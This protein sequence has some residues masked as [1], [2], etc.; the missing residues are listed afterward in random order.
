MS[1]KNINFDDNE[2]RES[3]FYNS[4]KINNIE[5]IDTN[6]ILVS[7]NESYSAKN[8]FKFFIGYNDNDVIRPLCIRLQQMTGYVKKCDENATMSFRVNNKQLLKS[9]NKIWEKVEKLMKVDF[10]SKPVHDDVYIK[11]KTKI[12]AGSVIT[13]F[14]NKEMPKAKAPCKRLSIIMLDSVIKANKNY[15]PQ[16]LLGECK[17]EQK[18]I[19]TENYIDEG[20]EI[21]DADNDSNDE[22]DNDNQ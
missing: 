9:Y 14:R 12:Y 17:Y 5:E 2:I 19:K 20:L 1:G 3:Y 22:T 11:T 7:K 18:K 16:T 13:N 15:Y 4:K 21:S 10:E 6:K 8:S